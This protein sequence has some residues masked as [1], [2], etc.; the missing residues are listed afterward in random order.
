MTYT[1]FPK[2]ILFLNTFYYLDPLSLVLHNTSLNVMAQAEFVV[3]MQ[4]QEERIPELGDINSWLQAPPPSPS[5]TVAGSSAPPI[6]TQ[7][8]I[9]QPPSLLL[10]L[11][12]MKEIQSNARAL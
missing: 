6:T 1:I 2:Y 11:N 12:V 4:H 3:I 5:D 10:Y 7:I 8:T 9:N